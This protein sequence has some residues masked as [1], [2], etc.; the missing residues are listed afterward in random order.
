MA[1]NN[2]ENQSC[3]GKSNTGNKRIFLYRNKINGAVAD[4]NKLKFIRDMHFH[5][6]DAQQGKASESFE[7]I[8]GVIS[9]IK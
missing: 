7:R 2:K 9:E 6:H 3:G 1:G 4:T 8:K 5:M